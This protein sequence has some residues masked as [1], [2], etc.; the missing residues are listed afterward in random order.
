MQAA[1]DAG[2]R[3]FDIARLYGDGSAEGVLGGVLKPVRDQV[4]VATKVGILPWSMQFGKRLAHKAA[5]AGRACGPLARRF[6]PA[7]P[8]AA[9]RYGAFG[10]RDMQ[11]SIEASL[12]A[13]RTDYLDILLLHECTPADVSYETLGLLERFLKAGKVRAW[14]IATHYPDTIRILREAPGNAAVVQIPSDPFNQNVRRLPAGNRLVVTHSALRHALPRLKNHLS[15]S[16]AAAARWE[17]TL[18]IPC[19]DSSSLARTLMGLALEDNS[20]G[21]VLFS[22]SRP[23]RIKDVMEQPLPAQ[24]LRAAREEIAKLLMP[25]GTGNDEIISPLR[26]ASS[27]REPV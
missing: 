10:R 25:E 14:G 20:G 17:A 1:F 4:V 23:E 16:P 24:M 21:V 12:K 5:K 6:I 27:G 22:T 11:R 19:D 3:Y 13:L 2:I 18:G 15:N 8:A 9:E 26:A 7:P